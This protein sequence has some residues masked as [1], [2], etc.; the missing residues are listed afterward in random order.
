MAHGVYLERWDRID[1]KR[2]KFLLADPRFPNLPSLSICL[3]TFE[4]PSKWGDFFGT[5]LRTYFVP[6]QTGN[7][8]FY[9]CKKFT[10]VLIICEYKNISIVLRDAFSMGLIVMGEYRTRINNVAV[11][12]IVRGYQRGKPLFS[13]R[14]SR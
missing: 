6:L 14:R 8:Y 12:I 2:V 5:R 10:L 1:Y 13:R 11:F 3:P 9:L 4:Q 7:H